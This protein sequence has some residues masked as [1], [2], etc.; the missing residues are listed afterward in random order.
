MSPTTGDENA[1]VIG[2]RRLRPLASAFAALA[3]A[4]VPGVVSV[5]VR[6][7]ASTVK[8]EAAPTFD[9][10]GD[11]TVIELARVESVHIYTG[12]LQVLLTPANAWPIG[13]P[14]DACVIETTPKKARVPPP[15][16]IWSNRTIRR[17]FADRVD[18]AEVR[19]AYYQGG[20]IESKGGAPTGE[21]AL[22]IDF[23]R[24]VEPYSTEVRFGQVQYF[25]V[26]H[27]SEYWERTHIGH[28]LSVAVE[29]VPDMQTVSAARPNAAQLVAPL[30]EMVEV[31]R[32]HGVRSLAVPFLGAAA[33]DG[34]DSNSY[35]VLLGVMI[36][37]AHNPG[38]IRA[39]Y[40]GAYAD[41]PVRREQLVAAVNRA[42][43]PVRQK[44]QARARQ[45]ADV[46]WRLTSLLALAAMASLLSRRR[47][48]GT[49]LAATLK[50][51]L[52]VLL[53]A[54][55]LAE[56]VSPVVDEAAQRFSLVAVLVLVGSAGGVLGW[57]L[58]L[59]ATFDPKGVVKGESP[60]A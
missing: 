30:T 24:A 36:E 50:M 38:S 33:A 58:P 2:A 60:R 37:A 22:A 7:W 31:A 42:W 32:E 47:L 8:I 34:L 19:R 45:L 12:T 56:T 55:G 27:S 17:M 57:L 29:P 51:A 49:S 40:V 54:K 4:A 5:A 11:G 52:A 18:P 14:R 43:Q 21:I 13:I 28:I 16:S 25:A 39:L 48:P 10:A 3:V 1:A 41:S 23:L 15:S 9:L 53:L 35:E 44:L 6:P 59:L 20:E 26:P 46:G